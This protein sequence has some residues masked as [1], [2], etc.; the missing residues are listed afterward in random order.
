MLSTIGIASII[1]LIL[2][3][4]GVP[5]FLSVLAGSGIYFAMN[6]NVSSFIYAQRVISSVQSLTLLAIP[7]FV[8]SGIFM[9][10][11]GVSKRI[12][13]LCDLITGRLW[14]GLAQVNVVMSTL[15]GGLSGSALADAAMES[16]IL[17][18]PM[19]K[20]GMSLEFSSVVTAASSM[21]TPII[22]PGI[23]MILCGSLANVSIGK[24]FVSGIGVGI[25]LCAG[26]MIT[27]SIISHKRGYRPT[28][29]SRM[30]WREA[31]PIIRASIA[32][33]CLPLVIIG[34]VRFGVFT[35]TEAGAVAV[36]YS[37]ILGLIYKEIN[38][39]TIV[40]AVKETVLST[41][42]IMMIIGAA[43]ALSWV[44]TKEQVPQTL[45]AF[46]VAASGTKY[47][48]MILMNLFLL[49]VGMFIEGNAAMVILVP[50]LF[51]IS[52]AFGI[53]EI[54]FLMVFILNMAIGSLTPPMGTLMFVVCNE[55]GCKVKEFIKES[56]PFYICMFAELIAL[57]F[58]PVLTTG[59][60]DLV[61]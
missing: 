14:G 4:C 2:L 55:T 3:F 46:M 41:A 7:F 16:R 53:N 19:V 49:F 8:C 47:V 9:N 27:V 39:E 23:A 38:L 12:M 32:P 45:T 52:Q 36:I 60:V 15:M 43:S 35:A 18:P 26:E 13:D 37:I 57:T 42:S 22:P 17:V 59:L 40:G 56:L 31:W 24:L 61:Y 20:K 54:H 30:P 50:L 1:M 5:V 21:I 48:F 33:M 34:G 6:P 29:D 51:P 58:I 28:R 25:L 11:S 44:L 10:Y